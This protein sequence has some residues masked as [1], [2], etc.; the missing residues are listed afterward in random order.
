[1]YFPESLSLSHELDLSHELEMYIFSE[2][3][4]KAI[5]A[6]AYLRIKEDSLRTSFVM[7]KVKLAPSHGHKIPRLDLCAA[8]LATQVAQIVQDNLCMRINKV[9]NFTDSRVVL[10]YLNNRTR[11]FYNY[12]SNR[13]ERILHVSKPEQWHY[14]STKENPAD[15]GTRG[16]ATGSELQEKWLC[17]P[18]LL[19]RLKISETQVSYPLIQPEH[20]KEIRVEVRKTTVDENFTVTFDYFF[21]WGKLINT[22][23]R[24]KMLAR[25]HRGKPQHDMLDET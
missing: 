13:G 12:V 6:V 7:G 3:S 15:H 22:I 19:T 23:S 21:D 17:G 2:V 16:L 20:D 11:R 9:Q 18:E 25:R 10:G 4:E 5:S 1:M 8:L 14:V 24:I